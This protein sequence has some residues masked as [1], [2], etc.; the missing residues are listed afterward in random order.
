MLAFATLYYFDA[1]MHQ[2]NN[3]FKK[4]VAD[5]TT[6][7]GDNNFKR[8]IAEDNCAPL[9]EDRPKCSGSGQLL[10]QGP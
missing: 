10:D 9:D 2:G 8:K 7:Q 3:N 5:V 6:H 4:K 1:T